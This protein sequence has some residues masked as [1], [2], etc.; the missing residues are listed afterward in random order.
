MDQSHIPVC[1]AVTF[2]FFFLIIYW[3]NKRSKAKKKA[4]APAHSAPRSTASSKAHS[5]ARPPSPPSTPRAA[6]TSIA[7]K[8]PPPTSSTGSK[9]DFWVSPSFFK[10]S[11]PKAKKP[12]PPAPKSPLKEKKSTGVGLDILLQN[13]SMEGSVWVCCYC[14][15]EN[16]LTAGKC[17]ICGQAR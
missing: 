14:G 9:G 8:S 16:Q 4:E 10:E 15:C 11:A 3:A 13:S 2:L 6:S 1:L 17:D 7:K 5:T 12:A